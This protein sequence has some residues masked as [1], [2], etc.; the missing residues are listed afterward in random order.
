MRTVSVTDAITAVAARVD[1]LLRGVITIQNTGAN[2]AAL[3]FDGSDAVLTAANGIEL[4]AGDTMTLQNDPGPHPEDGWLPVASNA[5]EAICATGL[6][7]TLRIQ[8]T[9]WD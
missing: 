7:T 2:T 1:P 5:I 9:A 6:T 8:E 4:L 3:K